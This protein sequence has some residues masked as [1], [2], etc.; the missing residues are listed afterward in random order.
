MVSNETYVTVR[1]FVGAVPTVYGNEAN[2]NTVV[3]RVGVTARTYN[4]EAGEY[5]SGTTGWYSVRCYGALGTNVAR[6]V[7]KGSPVLVRGRLVPRSWT[8]KNNQTH[9]DFNI[10]ADSVGIE[11]GTGIANFIHARDGDPTP[12][13]GEPANAAGGGRPAS[14]AG[15]AAPGAGVVGPYSGITT[16]SGTFGEDYPDAHDSSRGGSSATPEEYDV[17]DPEEGD[18]HSSTHGESGIWSTEEEPGDPTGNL[19]HVIE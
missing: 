7:R 4:R 6:C 5:Q 2:R 17:E 8:D 12:V 14:S 19:S 11:L 9:V 13:E 3:M 10:L 1:G 16:N 18:P 15:G